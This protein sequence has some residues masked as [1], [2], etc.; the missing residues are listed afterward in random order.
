MIEKL[1]NQKYLAMVYKENKNYKRQQLFVDSFLV[2]AALKGLSNLAMVSLKEDE[3]GIVQQ[4]LADIIT[5]FIDL[6]KVVEKFNQT[7]FGCS[8]SF[9]VLQ[10]N[11]PD[12]IDLLIQKLIFILNESIYKITHTF[13]TSLK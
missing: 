4:N 10:N 9:R 1:K 8:I 11:H 13:G 7:G 2:I 5:T 3:Y 6:Q 12:K